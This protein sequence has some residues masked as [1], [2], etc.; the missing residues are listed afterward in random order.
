MFYGMFSPPVWV[1]CPK[2]PVGV[3]VPNGF[4]LAASSLG[5]PPRPL[6]N[7]APAEE[8]AVLAELEPNRPPPDDGCCWERNSGYT[9]C[10]EERDKCDFSRQWT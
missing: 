7:A 6:K 4:L 10:R 3:V 2:P 9:M 8:P 1:D 5:L